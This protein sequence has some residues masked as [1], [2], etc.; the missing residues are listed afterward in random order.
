MPSGFGPTLSTRWFF[1]LF[2]IS[3]ITPKFPNF[4]ANIFVNTTQ[5]S[6]NNPW[7]AGHEN[8]QMWMA[9]H[10][11]LPLCDRFYVFDMKLLAFQTIYETRGSFKCINKWKKASTCMDFQRAISIRNFHFK[12]QKQA[13]EFTHFL[14]L[15]VV[16]NY[17]KFIQDNI[18]LC[19]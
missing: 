11:V 17:W 13:I 14:L 2:C 8:K 6:N 18:F 5:N 1:F 12:E 16:P 9:Y 19:N 7:I 15:T 4:S 3:W 10:G